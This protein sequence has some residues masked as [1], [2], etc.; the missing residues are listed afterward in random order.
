MTWQF[1]TTAASSERCTA[2][3]PGNH[4]EAGMAGRAYFSEVRTSMK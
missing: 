4:L 3:P 1:F 2:W